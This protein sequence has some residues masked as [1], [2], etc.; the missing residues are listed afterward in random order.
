M[1]KYII[2]DLD[3]TLIKSNN[4]TKDIIFNFFKEKQPEYYDVLKYSIDFKKTPHFKEIFIQVYGKFEEKEKK[5]H[6]EL[7]EYLD[8]A[9]KESVFKK[10]TIKKILKLKDRYSLYLS[11]GSSTKIAKQILKEGGIEQHFEII[12]GSEKIP[13]SEEHLDIFMEH[14]RDENFYKKSISIGDGLCDEIFAK[15]RDIDF[16]KIGKKYKNISD[17]KE[18]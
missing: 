7:Y 9:N 16:I 3:G 1:K 12:L 5:I 15:N 14:S 4:K 8:E 10:G 11:T 13:K 2:F 18:I 17:I 6:D